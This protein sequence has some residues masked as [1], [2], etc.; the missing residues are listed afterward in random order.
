[1]SSQ[2]S[3][4]WALYGVPRNDLKRL[5]QLKEPLLPQIAAACAVNPDVKDEPKLLTHDIWFK[6]DGPASNIFVAQ[7]VMIREGEV[8]GS[9]AGKSKH[10]FVG[11][12]ENL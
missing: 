12:L 1:M 4:P 9:F 8:E 2:S 11:A 7:A 6:K 3:H 5:L 10:D